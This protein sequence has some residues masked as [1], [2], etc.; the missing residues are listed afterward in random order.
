MSA[1]AVA[2]VTPRVEVPPG[3]TTPQ[4][5]KQ[6]MYASVACALLFLT[7]VFSGARAHREAMQIIG[8]DT[9]PGIIAAQHVAAA[10]ADMDASAADML[11]YSK[12]AQ[13]QNASSEAYGARRKEAVEVLIA[14]AENIKYEDERQPIRNIALGLSSYAEQIQAA[15]YMQLTDP[16]GYI[17]LYRNAAR[18]IDEKLLPAVEQLDHAK[19]SVFDRTYDD[20]RKWSSGTMLFLVLSSVALCGVLIAVQIFLTRRMRRVINPLLLT[21][22]GLAALSFFYMAESFTN[23]DHELKVAKEDAFESIH[24]LWKARSVA[25]SANADESRYLL[26][27]AHA[28]QYE[29]AFLEKADRVEKVDGSSGFLAD[30]MKNVTFPGESEAAVAAITQ[31]AEYKKIDQQIRALERSGQHV[32]AV[33]LCTGN[34]NKA[35][36]TFDNAVGETLQINQTAFDDAV[37]RGF[38]AVNHLEMVASILCGI[39]ALL[40]VLGLLPRLREY[41]AA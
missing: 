27:S 28:G 12:D 19:R 41:S 36:R 17:E 24:S 37:K 8:R 40:A 20:Q 14:A 21:A 39:I 10:I 6:G 18:T 9:A 26:D 22:T 15:R 1:P 5:L 2:R 35:F 4:L 30:E 11:L 29:Q 33:H 38:D 7:A 3:A 25:Y 31:F 32:S 23:A 13:N 16:R 34:S